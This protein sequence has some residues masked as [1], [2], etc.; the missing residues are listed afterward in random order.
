MNHGVKSTVAL[1]ADGHPLFCERAAADNSENALPRQHDPHRSFRE[2]GC[3]SRQYLMSPERLAAEATADEGRRYMDLL[4]LDVEYL[5]KRPGRVSDR[6]RGIMNPEFV[7]LP[8]QRSRTKRASFNPFIDPGIWISVK[9]TWISGRAFRMAMAS[10]ALAAWMTSK[11]ALSIASAESSR[12]KNSSSTIK[13]T[14]AK[15]VIT[16]LRRAK[17]DE[18][19][20]FRSLL[21]RA[22]A[23]PGSRPD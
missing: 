6:L 13:I 22:V 20:L 15:R 17:R 2:L 11:P 14:G 4:F 10:S 9:T 18:D 1:R 8:G 23:V 7:S 19:V 3:R 21:R 5:R 12:S 16:I